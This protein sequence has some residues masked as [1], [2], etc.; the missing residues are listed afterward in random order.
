MPPSSATAFSVRSRSRERRPVTTTV[1]PRSGRAA[2]L[3]ETGN[4]SLRCSSSLVLSRS[5]ARS[6]RLSASLSIAVLLM[7][8]VSGGEARMSSKEK[9]KRRGE[10]LSLSRNEFE[11]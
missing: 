5:L 10:K 1:L 2:I 4:C 7:S 9:L 8:F 3:K 11:E 6:L